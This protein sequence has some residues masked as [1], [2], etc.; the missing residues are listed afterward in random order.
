ME[1]SFKLW[2]ATGAPCLYMGIGTILCLMIWA[3]A[4]DGFSLAV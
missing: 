1:A 4:Y 2:A 3:V